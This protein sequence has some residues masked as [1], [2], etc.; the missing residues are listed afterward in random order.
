MTVWYTYRAMNDRIEIRPDVRFGKPVIR[1]T[2]V[3][4]TAVL[5]EVASGIPWT[6]IETE[7]GI[8]ADDIKAAVEFANELVAEQSFILSRSR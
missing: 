2:R 5:A 7:Y 4:V 1:G 3:P 8:T 6:E